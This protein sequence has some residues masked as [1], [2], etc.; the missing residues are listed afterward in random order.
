[1]MTTPDLAKLTATLPESAIEWRL[2]QCGEKNGRIWAMVIPYA[3]ARYLQGVLDAACGPQNWKDEYEPGPDGGVKC[4]LSIRFEGEWVTKENG[5]ENTDIEG[6]KGG[7]TTAFRRA[8]VNWN[9]AGIR[10]LYD[11]GDLWADVKEG[12]RFQGKTKTGARFNWS[13][14]KLSLP[15]SPA[16]ASGA[17]GSAPRGQQGLAAGESRSGQNTTPSKGL[18][19]D[20]R[21]SK[22][23]DI[24]GH[25]GDARWVAITAAAGRE[26][27]VDRPYTDDEKKHALDVLA[28]QYRAQQAQNGEVRA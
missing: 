13:P 4:K 12:G 24:L 17:T 5:A 9:V 2:Q 27:A 23:L 16:G 8:C 25:E 7:Y 21:L 15:S 14:P 11:V 19:L 26:P 18:T 22:A 3:D 6:V 28:K 1:M 20:Q 10:A